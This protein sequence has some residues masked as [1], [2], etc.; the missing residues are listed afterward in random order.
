L[1]FCSGIIQELAASQEACVMWGGTQ[2]PWKMLEGAADF[3]LRPD[4]APPNDAIREYLPRIGAH[5][6][7]QVTLSLADPTNILTVLHSTQEAK[8]TDPRDRLYAILGVVKDTTDIQIDYAKSIP[9]VYR[10]WAMRR[11]NRT[12]SLDILGACADSARENDLPSWVP[13]LRRLWGQDKQLWAQNHANHFTHGKSKTRKVKN[14]KNQLSSAKEWEFVSMSSLR[15]R[16]FRVG[17]ISSLSPIANV[18]ENLSKTTKVEERLFDIIQS[19]SQ[20]FSQTTTIEAN[21]NEKFAGAILRSINEPQLHRHYNNEINRIWRSLAPAKDDWS[22]DNTQPDE[23]TEPTEL[24]KFERL[25]FP[26]IHGCQ[27]FTVVGSISE[28]P[29]AGINSQVGIVAGN[30]KTQVD[31]EVWL[32]PALNNP[33]ILRRKDDNLQVITTCYLSMNLELWAII[34]KDRSWITLV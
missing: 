10:E 2:I 8:C 26:R 34:G 27:M 7:R 15:V 24:P 28:A 1:L 13:D 11:I 31:D 9:D 4:R 16:G 17:T 30:C 5:R 14:S 12:A 23:P 21:S 22:P 6:L 3:I 20:W 32:L 18:V 33:I 19:W 25:M 29:R